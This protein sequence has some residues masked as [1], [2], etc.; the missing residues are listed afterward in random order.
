MGEGLNPDQLRA[1]GKYMQRQ[2]EA[3][4]LLADRVR[5]MQER[6]ER[7]CVQPLIDSEAERYA[8]EMD[9][10]PP[11][12]MWAELLEDADEGRRAR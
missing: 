2:A 10:I 8:R 1:I 7:E 4:K 3:F 11:S 6:V 5:E 12:R 9:N